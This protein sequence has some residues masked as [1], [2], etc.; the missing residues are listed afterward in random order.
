MNYGGFKFSV[1][2]TGAG[3]FNVLVVSELQMPTS[4]RTVINNSFREFYLE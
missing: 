3:L 2:G 1:D 4:F